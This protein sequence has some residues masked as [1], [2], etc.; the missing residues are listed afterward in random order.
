MYFGK[1]VIYLRNQEFDSAKEL[2]KKIISVDPNYVLGL[3]TL[4]LSEFSLGNA[5]EALKLAN[6]LL[7]KFNN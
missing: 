6:E 5:D 4:A 1:A 7:H 2:S 3:Y